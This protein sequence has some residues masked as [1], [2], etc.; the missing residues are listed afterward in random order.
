LFQ[1]GRLAALESQAKVLL[2][3][4]EKRYLEIVFL[5]LADVENELSREQA[6]AKRV[7]AFIQ[8]E[9]NAVAAQALAFDQYQRGLVSYTTVL[10]S[11][12]RAFDAETTLIQLRNQQLKNRANLLLALGGDY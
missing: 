3:Q 1:G 12:R 7:D 10:E 4:Q 2:E 8:A 5:A 11:Q 6:L 9:Q